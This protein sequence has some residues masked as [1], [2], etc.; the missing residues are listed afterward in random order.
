[1]PATEVATRMLMRLL[2]CMKFGDSNVKKMTRMISA[3]NASN[4]WTASDLKSELGC[5]IAL[6]I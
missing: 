5:L 1:M 2:V 3:E 6:V 4:R